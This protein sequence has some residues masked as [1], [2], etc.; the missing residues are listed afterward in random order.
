[1]PDGTSTATRRLLLIKITVAMAAVV[2][3]CFLLE[4][5]LR[6]YTYHIGRGFS[7][8]PHTFISPFFTSAHWPPPY[9]DDGTLVFKEGERIRHG[10]ASDRIRI[11]C[12]GGS[13]TLPSADSEG[14]SYPR[15]LERLLR[16]RF[17]GAGIDVL[18]AAENSFSTAHLL[19]SLS[20]RLSDAQ[21]SIVT[22]YE[23]I[24][25]LSVNYFG[26]EVMS[27]YANKYLEPYYLGY[28]HRVGILGELGRLSRLVRV[29]ENRTETIIFSI[30]DYDPKRDYRP[31]LKYYERN[32]RSIVAVAHAQGVDVV[33]G[34]QAARSTLRNDE[35]FVAYND[36]VRRV[37]RDTGVELSDVAAVELDD[38]YFLDDV[39]NTS[40]GARHVAQSWV[41]PVAGL[42]SRRLSAA[43][44]A[45]ASDAASVAAMN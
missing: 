16:T 11:I 22:V 3:T 1:M 24:N 32:L 31:G 17:P 37:A 29:I 18:N 4:F 20:L 30:K 13:T 34:T 21:P 7:E 43:K 5:A 27:D 9:E 19:V 36:T 12:L 44:V 33:L 42:V 28:R 26:T 38:S 41:D 23:N 6:L 39:H 14:V 25:D 10:G 8:D 2:V 40:A 35:G 15:E 45:T